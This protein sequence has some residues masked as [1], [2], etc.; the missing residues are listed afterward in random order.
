MKF[1]TAALLVASVASRS[2]KFGDTCVKAEDTCC[3]PDQTDDECAKN[4]VGTN[5][6]N[7]MITIVSTSKTTLCVDPSK[8]QVTADGQ[9]YGYNCKA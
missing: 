5:C 7:I 9:S 1:T 4:E 8:K 3:L 6:C 2:R